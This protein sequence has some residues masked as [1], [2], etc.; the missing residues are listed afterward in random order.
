VQSEQDQ[1]GQNYDETEEKEEL[2]MVT[3]SKSSQAN[4]CDENS[5]PKEEGESQEAIFESVQPPGG[6]TP[7]ANEATEAAASKKID[8][9]AEVHCTDT[10]SSS[11]ANLSLLFKMEEDEERQA[12]NK[13]VAAP[14]EL[15][16]SL[17]KSLLDI[18]T[19]SDTS[20]SN[21]T[22]IYTKASSS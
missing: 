8:L 5:R 12:A 10:D 7:D 17:N 6:Q 22:A 20:M 16:K 9:R 3:I 15:T 2:E 14:N 19:N 21:I 18:V 1:A 13:D 4:V 11:C